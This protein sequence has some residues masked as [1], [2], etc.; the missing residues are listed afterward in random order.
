MKSPFS[1]S[2]FPRKRKSR[3]AALRRLPWVP[4]FAGTAD[5]LRLAFAL[6]LAASLSPAPA[7]GETKITVGTAG[8]A[9]AALFAAKHEGFF[10][11]RGLDVTITMIRL[12]PDLPPALIAGS[13]DVAFMTTPTF[14]QAIE[15]GIDLVAFAGGTV[16]SRQPSDQAVIAANGVQI[17]TAQDFLGH[18]IGVPGIGAGL[19]VLF[20]YWLDQNGVDYNRIDFAEISM[21]QMRDALAARTIDAVVAVEPFVSQMLGAGVGYKALALS[22]AIPTGKP[23]VI[24]TATRDWAAQHAPEIAAFRAAILEGAA[25]A[26]TEPDKTRDD[27]NIYAKLPPQIMKTI[28][29]SEQ[30]PALETEQLAWWSAVMKKQHM[31]Q[32]EIDVPKLLVK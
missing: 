17:K 14:F 15:G 13:L 22:D 19:H 18:K 26:K 8:T 7:R 5:Y 10:A 28:A 12:N 24:Y 3:I 21:P 20:R 27:V 25:F 16:T 6:L 30:V 32:R 11:K 31:L 1:S 23:M 29:I 4:A 2:S 9:A